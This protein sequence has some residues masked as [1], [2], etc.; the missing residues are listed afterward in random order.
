[1]DE[2]KDQFSLGSDFIQ[3]LM[4]PSLH[5]DQGDNYAGKL[6]EAQTSLTPQEKNAKRLLRSKF[7]ASYATECSRIKE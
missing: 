5:G 2:S 4:R 7:P 3:G 1:M 6:H